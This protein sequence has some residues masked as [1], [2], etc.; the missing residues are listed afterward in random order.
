MAIRTR[1]L[2]LDFFPVVNAPSPSLPS[3]GLTVCTQLH[4]RRQTLRARRGKSRKK[5]RQRRHN[6][7]FITST[8]LSIS[9]GTEMPSL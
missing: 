3:G 6:A 7:L 1:Y 2:S 8:R 4:P 5:R 9:A